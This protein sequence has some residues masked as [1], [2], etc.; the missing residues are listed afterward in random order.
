VLRG[1]E[2]HPLLHQ[3]GCVT[4]ARD[5][6]SM[7]F[8]RKLIEVHAPEH[9]PGIGWR[10]QQSNSALDSCVEPYAV[11]FRHALNTGLEHRW[12]PKSYH[13]A[14]HFKLNFSPIFN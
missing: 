4:D 10:G 1:R 9:N 14:T 12:I 11:G 13:I 8:N 5:I 3:A 2:Q 7:R 6:P